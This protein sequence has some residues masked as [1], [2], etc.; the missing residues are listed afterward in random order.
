MESTAGVL[1]ARPSALTDSTSSGTTTSA[2][3]IQWYHE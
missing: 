2:F 3:T 1:K